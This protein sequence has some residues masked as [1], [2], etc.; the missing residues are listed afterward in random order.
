[1]S[2][3]VGCISCGKIYQVD[4]RFAGKKAKCKTCGATLE[5]PALNKGTAAIGAAPGATPLRPKTTAATSGARV[6]GAPQRVVKQVAAV[7]PSGGEYDLSAMDDIERSGT[8][9]DTP[10]AP[11]KL[12]PVAEAP[13]KKS[14]KGTVAP[15][16]LRGGGAAAAAGKTMYSTTQAT[17]GGSA[18]FIESLKPGAFGYVFI[19]VIVLGLALFSH[20]KAAAIGALL[21][22]LTGL[23]CCGFAKLKMLSVA[24]DEGFSTYLMYRFVP[25]YSF[26][27]VCSRW[28]D[29][30]VAVYSWLK[31]AAL[32]VLALALL[33]R[34]GGVDNVLSAI[35]QGS[36][37]TASKTGKAGKSTK[38]AADD[39]IWA[40]DGL[41]PAERQAR[42]LQKDKES[43]A[44]RPIDKLDLPVRTQFPELP[45]VTD[46]YGIPMYALHLVG[47]FVGEPMAL[48]LYM[49][50]GKHA[51]HSLPCV[52]MFAATGA[53]L[54]GQTLVERDSREALFLARSGVA[55]LVFDTSRWPPS[56]RPQAAGA[57]EQEFIQNDCGRYSAQD[58]MNFALAKVP[59][60][61]PD[62]LYAAGERGGAR[63]ALYWAAMEPRIKGVAAL[64]PA[65][66]VA[67]HLDR[68]A[69][70]LESQFKFSGVDE[71]V[72]RTSPINRVADIN[73]PVLILS[74]PNE[75]LGA[76]VQ[77]FITAMKAAGKTVV[78]DTVK[79]VDRS[80]DLMYDGYIP[81]IGEWFK[82]LAAAT[83]A[84]RPANPATKPSP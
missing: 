37:A 42:R 4:D 45:E 10:Q 79:P 9:D 62:R 61:N 33:M 84:T 75:P 12:A 68:P 16:Y 70:E 67:A 44:V 58:A 80:K 72:K 1:M 19:G 73:C 51:D 40:D 15:A 59:A 77:P 7:E 24:R 30:Q 13:A 34:A 56:G 28:Q 26:Y 46:E 22:G 48:M 53:V 41:T 23:A 60:I 83:P 25:F 5:V 6:S 81:Q 78:V 20:E 76:D 43:V 21:V 18:T 32:L 65:C 8:I 50:P 52:F 69:T 14:V 27:F 36:K 71:F 29:A 38:A 82:G 63:A 31:G 17:A 74:L 2:I 11:V 3:K 66:D 54:E 57:G 47:G 35:G 64:S 49:P 55:A 39:D